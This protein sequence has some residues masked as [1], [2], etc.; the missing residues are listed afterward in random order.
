[1]HRPYG[2]VTGFELGDGPNIEKDLMI[3]PTLSPKDDEKEIPFSQIFDFMK[4]EFEE[5]DACIVVGC[6]FRDE[7]INEVF[8]EFIRKGKML[9]SISPT[10]AKDLSDN[11]FKSANLPAA[12]SASWSSPQNLCWVAW[13][14]LRPNSSRTTRQS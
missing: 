5:Q 13:S 14:D 11:F 2:M 3:T 9:I 7:G 8:G 12:N 6:S 10:V 4:K 1:M